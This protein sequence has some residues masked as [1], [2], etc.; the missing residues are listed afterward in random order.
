MFDADEVLRI[1]HRG[2]TMKLAPGI[3]PE[4]GKLL[5]LTFPWRASMQP[6]KVEWLA[7]TVFFSD[8]P[9]EVYLACDAIHGNLAKFAV[10]DRQTG[11]TDDDQ[12]SSTELMEHTKEALASLRLIAASTDRKVI[13][14]STL[15]VSSTM[16]GAVPTLDYAYTLDGQ[17]GALLAE[18]IKYDPYYEIKY[19][20]TIFRTTQKHAEFFTADRNAPCPCHSG[21]KYKKC[22]GAP[23]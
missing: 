13:I 7:P 10:E 23:R 14:D 8:D 1:Y 3:N 12:F 16:I 6:A 4:T 15:R 19:V 17:V 9:N 2:K 22:H 21:K 20:D 11:D 18:A 5:G